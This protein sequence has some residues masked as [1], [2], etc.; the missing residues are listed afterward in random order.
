MTN[1]SSLNFGTENKEVWGERT[2]LSDSSRGLEPF[3]CK[4]IIEN[5][6]FNYFHKKNANPSFF[7]TLSP[8]FKVCNTSLIY[9]HSRVSKALLNILGRFSAFVLSIISLLANVAA[10]SK[11]F[12]IRVD[13]VWKY[14]FN[15]SCHSFRYD[16]VV[17]VE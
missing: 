6:R 13:N 14:F 9:G 5:C 2:P 15:P 8:K 11:L 4:A 3:G 10:F 1:F 7:I 12:F 16:L 17:G